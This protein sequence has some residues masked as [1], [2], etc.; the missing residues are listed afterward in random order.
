MIE[1]ILELENLHA[2]SALDSD[3]IYDVVQITV[4]LFWDKSTLTLTAFGAAL[5]EPLLDALFVEYLF[6]LAALD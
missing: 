4:L 3:L 2:V 1:S 5:G 6:A